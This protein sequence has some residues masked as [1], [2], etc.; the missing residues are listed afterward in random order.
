MLSSPFPLVSQRYSILLHILSIFCFESLNVSV[1][2]PMVISVVLFQAGTSAESLSLHMI[3]IS[4]SA[5]DRFVSTGFE[6]VHSP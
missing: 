4:I 6:L 1:I 2:T 3:I 5:F